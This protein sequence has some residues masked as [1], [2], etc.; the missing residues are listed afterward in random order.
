MTGFELARQLS[1]LRAD[2]PIVMTS[3]YVAP[4]DEKTALAMGALAIIQKPETVEELGARLIRLFRAVGSARTG[5]PTDG[6]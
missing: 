3:G 2:L 6:G 5:N 1:V 4:E